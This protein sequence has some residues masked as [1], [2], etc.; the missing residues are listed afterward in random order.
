MAEHGI[1]GPVIGLA[2]D[3]TGYGADGTVWGG[4]ILLADYHCFERVGHFQHVALPGGDAA[5]RE[6]WRMALAYLHHAFGK[7]LFDLPIEFIK[8][9]DPMKAGIVLSM[10][11]KNLNAPQTSSCGRLFDGV[12]SLVGLRDR[13]SYRGQAAVELEMEMGEGED[14]YSVVIPREGELIIPHAPIIRGIVTDLMEGMNRRTISRRFHNTLVRVFADACIELRNRRKLN[15][16]VLSGGVF[17]NAFLLGQLEKILGE[18]GFEVY[19]PSLVPAND[20]GISLG[21]TVVA[22]AV[23]DR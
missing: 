2:M 8:R 5:I 18:L 9:L 15:R 11:E 17:Q 3:G 1:S 13:S 20:G 23:L 6:P 22:N 12:A 19:T 16:V 7:G 21:Q 10:I 4:E 14:Y